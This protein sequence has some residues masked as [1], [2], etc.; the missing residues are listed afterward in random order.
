[1]AKPTKKQRAS[2]ADIEKK[3]ASKTKADR[4][5][6]RIDDTYNHNSTMKHAAKARKEGDD[7]TYEK[8]K[9][10]ALDTINRRDRKILR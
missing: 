6:G 4:D 5:K 10:Q 1:M 7:S 2:I 3:Y 9:K 8:Y